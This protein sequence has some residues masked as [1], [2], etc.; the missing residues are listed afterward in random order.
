MWQDGRGQ[1]AAGQTVWTVR[2]VNQRAKEL[3]ERQFY[4]VRIEGEISGLKL[5]R[6]GHRYFSLKDESGVLSAALFRQ[7]SGGL[8]FVPRDG[9][10]VVATGTVTIYGPQGRYQLMVSHLQEAG[11]GALQAAFEAMRRRLLAE[12]LFEATAKRPLPFLPRR[13]AVITS[14]TGAVWRDILQISRRRYPNPPLLLVPSRVQG[15]GAADELAA[16]LRR[17]GTLCGPLGIDVVLL[18]RGGGSLEDLWAFN[19]EGLA[20]AIRACPVPVVSGVGH[21]TDTT[22]ADFA[23][24][25]RAP[26]PS[27]AAER[28]FPERRQL[29]AN[30][31]QLRA[32][33]A[34]AASGRLGHARLRLRAAGHL[35]GDGQRLLWQP[36]QRLAALDRRLVQAMQRRLH[37]ARQ[38]HLA[39]ERRLQ[40]L[41]PRRKLGQLALRRQ[42]A[43][44]VLDR[45]LHQRLA[46]LQGRLATLTAKL[47]ALS[48]LSVLA[49]GYAIVKTPEGKAVRRAAEVGTG[50]RLEVR[51]ADGALAVQVA[52][53][54]PAPNA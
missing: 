50:A 27:A 35:L 48:P 39:L 22:I 17:V 25:V 44:Q 15:Q 42:R 8:T 29:A 28:I 51:L 12:G 43:H 5:D 21:E 47:E 40:G 53:G 23:A 20:R 14:P 38:R 3:M 46:V 19:D 2:Q 49:R 33:L 45:C 37:H 9:S 4:Q 52:D 6:S 10:K 34:Q 41:H 1:A 31:A 11:A 18:A 13:V 32:R 24:D 36:N 54:A 16:A 7:R 26:T 30:V